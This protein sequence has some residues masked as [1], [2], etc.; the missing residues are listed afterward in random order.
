LISTSALLPATGMPVSPLM[1]G[2]PQHT[3][4]QMTPA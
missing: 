3:V 4:A 1:T 2:I